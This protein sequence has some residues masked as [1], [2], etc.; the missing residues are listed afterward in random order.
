MK[1][2]QPQ[3]VTGGTKTVGGIAAN[4][5]MRPIIIVLALLH[6]VIIGLIVKINSTSADLSETMK[7]AGEQI[8]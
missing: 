7:T 2:T 5:L 3:Q 6:I 8:E 4:S 1:S